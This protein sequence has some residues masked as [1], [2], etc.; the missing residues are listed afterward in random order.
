MLPNKYKWIEEIGILPKLLSA[1][2]Q[3]FGV[4]EIPG[5]KN[6][7]V[8]MDMA[9]G[10]GVDKIY[11]NDDQSWCAVFIN[12]LIRIT[13]KPIDLHP[14]D[15]YDLL[16]A[17]Q[18]ATKFNIVKKEDAVLSDIVQLSRDGGGHVCL[19]IAKTPKGFI[20]YGGN[21]GNKVSFVEFDWDRI[22][23][24]KRYYATAPP[25]SAIRYNMDSEGNM[26]V[27]EA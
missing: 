2:L 6:N 3:Y 14:K 17:R 7:P 1:G 20:G 10:L 24:V 21:Q 13:G 16:R 25:K 27:N 8:I 26:S 15:L 22:I 9:K 18:T 11:T 19:F 5:V 12:H 4:K 23:A